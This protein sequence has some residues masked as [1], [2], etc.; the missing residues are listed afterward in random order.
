MLGFPSPSLYSS[1]PCFSGT[2]CEV[3]PPTSMQNGLLL[4]SLGC[5]P[6]WVP[7]MEPGSELS[8]CL[9]AAL[10]CNFSYCLFMGKSPK[11]SSAHLAGL[12]PV[13]IKISGTQDS[14]MWAVKSMQVQTERAFSF[15]FL[16]AV[17][18]S[19]TQGLAFLPW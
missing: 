16:T 9:V 17:S 4:T 10:S 19:M 2:S 8:G 1:R 14:L 12:F 15:L 13:R 18:C 5:C 6:V 3:L 7:V 11:Y